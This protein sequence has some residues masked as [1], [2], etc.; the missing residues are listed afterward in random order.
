MFSTMGKCCFFDMSCPGF[1]WP[2]VYRITA[3]L[4]CSV[5]KFAGFKRA[6]N[7]NII[8]RKKYFFILLGFIQYRL[9][10]KWQSC[11]ESLNLLKTKQ[12]VL[13]KES[14]RTAQ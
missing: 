2:N 4:T 12:S 7:H 9:I 13:Y 10:I 5:R 1:Y 6:D 14:V 3:T 8:Y 11:P